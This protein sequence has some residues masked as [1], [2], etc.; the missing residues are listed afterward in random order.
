L[1]DYPTLS[2][3]LCVEEDMIRTAQLFRLSRL[4]GGTLA[5]L[6]LVTAD[7]LLAAGNPEAGRLLIER[8]CAGCHGAANS[9]TVTDAAPS[10]SA[11]ALRNRQNRTWVRA[12]LTGPHPAMP[13]VDLSRRQIDDIVAYLNSLPAN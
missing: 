9:A 12:W 2:H 8:S 5:A 11:I 4:L 1:G 13:G 3:L 6:A 10:F 7:P